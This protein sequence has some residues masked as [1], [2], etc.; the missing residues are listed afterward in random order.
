MPETLNIT[1]RQILSLH[2]ALRAL[3]GMPSG[4]EFIRFEFADNV[5]WNITKN[6]IIAEN[7]AVAYERRKGQIMREAGIC[8]GQTVT[9]E[10]AV[11][12]AKMLDRLEALKDETNDLTGLLF[13]KRA[14]LKCEVNKI[15]PSV[16]AGLDPIIRA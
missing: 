3:D 12:V 6:L 11:A 4:S 2:A 7:A 16:R 15:P 9:A 8:Q 10:N 5:A 13:L 1:N 14:D